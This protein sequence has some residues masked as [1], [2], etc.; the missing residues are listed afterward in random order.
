LAAAIL[1]TSAFHIDYS[2]E[3]R[4]YALLALAATL[5]AAAAFFFVKSTSN[6]ARA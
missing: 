3:A 2:Q 5:Y 4:M 6:P 1:A